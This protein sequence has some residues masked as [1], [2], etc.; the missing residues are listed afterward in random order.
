[1]HFHHQFDAAGNRTA[2]LV[3]SDTGSGFP[4]NFQDIYAY[5]HIGHLVRT[6]QSGVPCEL[7]Q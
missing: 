4:D 6:A 2:L 3:Q 5:D 1:M 7:V